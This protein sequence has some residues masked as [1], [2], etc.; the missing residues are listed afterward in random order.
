MSSLS[1]VERFS[2]GPL[3]EVPLDYHSY[4]TESGIIYFTSDICF[5]L[6]YRWIAYSVFADIGMFRL[7]AWIT[8]PMYLLKQILHLG[9]IQHLQD[10]AAIDQKEIATREA[11]RSTD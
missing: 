9:F 11:A 2:E 4:N 1:F 6:F 5:I 7:L 10:V 8:F 3:L